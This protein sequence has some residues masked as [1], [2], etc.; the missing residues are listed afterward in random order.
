VAMR[1][2]I[3]MPFCFLSIAVAIG[4][5]TTATIGAA[6]VGSDVFVDANL[7]AAART[8]SAVNRAVP[9]FYG[10]VLPILQENC[11]VCHQLAAPDDGGRSRGFH[12]ADLV[13]PMALETYEQTQPWARVIAK[14]VKDREMPPWSAHPQHKGQFLG[15][16]YLD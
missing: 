1:V 3:R 12:A 5:S 7:A 2:T 16:R 10:D 4:V 14:V 13:A 6:Q 9:T 8:S 15:E 11:Q